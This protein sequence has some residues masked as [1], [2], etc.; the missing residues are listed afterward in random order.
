MCVGVGLGWGLW[1]WSLGVCK[2]SLGNV[3]NYVSVKRG[4]CECDK[5]VLKC[6][7]G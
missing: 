7:C 5:M 2:G 3:V 6:E 4:N 1:V